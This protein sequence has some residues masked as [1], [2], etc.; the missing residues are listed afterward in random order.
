MAAKGAGRYRN[1]L[2]AR[3]LGLPRATLDEVR[4]RARTLTGARMD[5]SFGTCGC[6]ILGERVFHFMQEFR[7]K[8]GLF[9]D[10]CAVLD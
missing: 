2:V 7:R 6:L 5:L 3:T 1:S 10:G 9:K 8:E 4:W